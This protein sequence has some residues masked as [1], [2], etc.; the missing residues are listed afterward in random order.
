ML[1]VLEQ[2]P[3][4][5]RVARE[6]YLD[7]M[8]SSLDDSNLPEGFKDY[9]KSQDIDN[10]TIAKMLEV[11]PRGFFDVFDNNGIFIQINAFVGTQ[12]FIWNINDDGN[13]KHYGSRKEA[14][15]D[16]VIKAF[17]LLNEKL[18]QTES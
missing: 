18:C 4:A 13:N 12:S 11:S 2:Y 3:E 8:L 14:E 16:A 9:V 10:E 5:A 15:T 1:E 6:W 17:E 7:K